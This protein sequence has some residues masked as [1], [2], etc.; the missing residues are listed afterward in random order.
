M[1][2]EAYIFHIVNSYFTKTERHFMDSQD[3]GPRSPRKARG[4]P[5]DWEDKTAQNTIK[6]LDRAME[7]FEF[8]S[9]R[10]GMALS[11]IS[12]EMGQ[13]PS[14]VYRVLV[15]LEGR[16]LVEFDAEEQLWHI[17]ARAFTIGARADGEGPRADVPKLF[18]GIEFH[19][20]TALERD[21]HAIDRRGR[22]PHL[23]RDRAERHALPLAQELED[24][25][26][27]VQRLDGV[28]GGLVLPVT[29]PAA[30]L[31][32]AARTIILRIHEMPFGFCE[33]RIHNM[34]NISFCK[35]SLVQATRQIEKRIQKNI[36]A[37]PPRL[38][39][40]A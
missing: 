5:R 2:T 32:R 8:L 30:C 22:L 37:E 31:A 12:D 29:R 14:T 35:H 40:P 9:E 11:T 18:L 25:H 24:L 23:V 28:L 26:G 13:S 36:P 1:F 15:T 10:Q 4:R 33:I 6:S 19:Q 3:N 27:T 20:P 21:Q 34:K 38:R 39:C 16:G 7:V 17:G